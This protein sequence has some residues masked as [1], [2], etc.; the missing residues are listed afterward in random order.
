MGRP[1]ARVAIDI[2]HVFVP[3]IMGIRSQIPKRCADFIQGKPF[4]V[5]PELARKRDTGIPG[6]P[7]AT[8]L[9]RGRRFE[10]K[11]GVLMRQAA[12]V[13]GQLAVRADDAVT[14]DDDRDRVAPVGEAD[15]S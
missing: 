3:F 4:L 14:G 1:D 15:R 10:G 11:Q 12:A 8:R 9:L 2:C 6:L 13:A 7:L 5:L